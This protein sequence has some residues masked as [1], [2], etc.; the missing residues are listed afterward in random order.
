MKLPELH[1][2]L[3]ITERRINDI[4]TIKAKIETKLHGLTARTITTDGE[5]AFKMI[6]NVL[7]WGYVG[8]YATILRIYKEGSIVIEKGKH[9]LQIRWTVRLENLFIIASCY[10]IM[11]GTI[12][13]FTLSLEIIYSIIV[14]IAFFLALVILGTQFIKYKL[15]ELIESSVYPNSN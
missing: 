13:H 6:T 4:H 12:L 9:S 15:T 14:S 3:V 8:S 1:D 2:T 10:S 7:P 11:F 5:I